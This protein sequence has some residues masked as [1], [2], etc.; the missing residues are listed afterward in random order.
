MWGLQFGQGGTMRPSVRQFYR[1]I[2]GFVGLVA[3][4]AA[5]FYP[6]VVNGESVAQQGNIAATV[7]ALLQTRQAVVATITAS[8][9]QDGATSAQT[10]VK[11]TPA[12][13]NTPVDVPTNTPAKVSSLPLVEVLVRGLNIRSGPGTRY[14]VV[15][16]ANAGQQFVILGQASNCAWLNVGNPDN[17]N[18][19]V[20]WISGA[21]QYASYTVAC[22]TITSALAPTRQIVATPRPTAT[23]APASGQTNQTA[24]TGCYILENQLSF[25][26][27]IKLSRADGWSDSFQLDPAARR[28]YCAPAGTY[29][30]TISL[31]PPLSSINGVLTISAG[32]RFYLPLKL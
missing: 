12:P 18:S 13:T 14:A 29:N 31:P 3:I 6:A 2:V 9:P 19:E 30:Y 4:N 10:G 1:F 15:S 20:G 23:P 28:E 11:S 26:L 24:T 5:F 8:A 22:S 32:D 27:T 21:A 17:N 7:A 25:T 16:N